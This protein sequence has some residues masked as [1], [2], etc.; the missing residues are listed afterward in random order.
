ME[1]TLCFLDLALPA[2]PSDS[3]PPRLAPVMSGNHRSFR[4]VKSL[5]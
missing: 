2:A 1:I 3:P 4:G 5:A